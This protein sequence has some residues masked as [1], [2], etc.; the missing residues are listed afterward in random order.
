[1]SWIRIKTMG[2]LTFSETFKG[3]NNECFIRRMYG[4][5]SAFREL[6]KFHILGW[7]INIFLNYMSKYLYQQSSLMMPSRFLG[8]KV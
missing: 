1:M 6:L 2:S 4:Q 5:D 3:L 8:L 7:G